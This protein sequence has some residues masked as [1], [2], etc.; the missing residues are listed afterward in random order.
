MDL[1][2]KQ[3]LLFLFAISVVLFPTIFFPL[4][5]D[6]SV[7]WQ[8]AKCILQGGT[9]YQDW[10]DIKPP[11]I[12]YLL[13]GIRFIFGSSEI[14]IR[15]FD[16]IY[17]LV[18]VVGIAVVA[19]K[20]LKNDTTAWFC[21]LFYAITYSTHGFSNTAQ[22]ETM[23]ALP[24]VGVVY[25]HL[26]SESK[27]LNRIALGLILGIIVGFKFTFLPFVLAL[28]LD[29]IMRK[30]YNFSDFLVKYSIIIFGFVFGIVLAFLPLL[31]S[32]VRANYSLVMKFLS[33]YSEANF[34]N[35]EYIR[36]YFKQNSIHFG[37]LYSIAFVYFIVSGIFNS[38]KKSYRP[39]IF[40]L[41]LLALGMYLS[42][43]LERRYL[44]YHF[45]RM[46]IPLSIIAGF[47]FSCFLK[48]L[49]R[50]NKKDSYQMLAKVIIILL[51]IIISPTLRWLGLWQY[52]I[53]YIQGETAYNHIKYDPESATN[54]RPEH[55]EIAKFLNTKVNPNSIVTVV[56]TGGGV[57]HQHL[58][59][60]NI[61][62]F[63]QPYFHYNN[64]N[65]SIWENAF[66]EEIR[67]ADFIV[68]Q[69]NDA[70]MIKDSKWYTSME[71]LKSM[72]QNWIYIEDNFVE[73]MKTR[74]FVVL[75]RE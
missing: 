37:D 39:D 75:G 59:T 52:P 6:L 42:V 64:L 47:G 63:A 61:T 10:I 18:T 41:L 26:F 5:G 62:S 22:V 27:T 58:N 13:A 70:L 12:Y 53:K 30:K 20:I 33:G 14:S 17:Q 24:M 66:D 11:L 51:L 48:F 69:T 56:N 29:D 74:N 28:P 32:D 71:M 7:F 73:L 50:I 44:P 21:A 57:I 54:L 35:S 49:M 43:A 38:F 15:L 36:F 25:L 55:I 67:S 8:G 1:K 3:S 60:D 45:Q 72:H 40:F 4:S 65:I 16:F 31:S 68:I 2:S 19:D 23:I 9:I 34:L 46:Y